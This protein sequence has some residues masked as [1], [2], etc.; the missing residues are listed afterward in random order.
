MFSESVREPEKMRE[1]ISA[2]V[3]SEDEDDELMLLLSK[4]KSILFAKEAGEVSYFVMLLKREDDEQVPKEISLFETET[5]VCEEE[6][7][8]ETVRLP[9]WTIP[10]LPEGFSISILLFEMLKEEVVVPIRLQSLADISMRFAE[11]EN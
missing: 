9:R 2:D 6:D 3:N 4:R 1:S 7:V 10:Q 8:G 11:G 5:E